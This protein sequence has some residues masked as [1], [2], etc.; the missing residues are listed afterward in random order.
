MQSVVAS[1][2]IIKPDETISR[3]QEI[4]KESNSTPTDLKFVC[5]LCVIAFG[6]FISNSIHHYFSLYTKYILDP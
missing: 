4:T 5:Y 6:H 3:S 2:I 1:S